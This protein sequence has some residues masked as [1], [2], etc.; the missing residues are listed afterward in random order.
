MRGGLLA[1]VGCAALMAACSS[2][3]DAGAPAP[4]ADERK[5]VSEAEAMIPETERAA[6]AD[7]EATASAKPTAEPA[8]EEPQP[9]P[10]YRTPVPTASPAQ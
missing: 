6:P 10:A 3:E 4:S 7:A 8:T 9:K 2:P 5:A 1:L